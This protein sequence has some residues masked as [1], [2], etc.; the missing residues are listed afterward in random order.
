M[1]GVNWSDPQTLW[2]N[3]TNLALGV[4]TLAALL[5]VAGA[6][7]WELVFKHRRARQTADLDAELSS[8]LGAASPHILHV[9]GLGLTMADGGTPVRPEAESSQSKATRK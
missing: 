7:G 9:S 1:F 5:I 8:I 6:V 2:L 4:V 3:I